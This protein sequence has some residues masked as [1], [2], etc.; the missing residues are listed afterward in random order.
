MCWKGADNIIASK[1]N[2]RVGRDFTISVKWQKITFLLHSRKVQWED[3]YSV[4]CTWFFFFF[5]WVQSW[6]ITTTFRGPLLMLGW[7]FTIF[8]LSVFVQLQEFKDSSLPWGSVLICLMACE[9]FLQRFQGFLVFP[10]TRC[11]NWL[12][13]CWSTMQVYPWMFLKVTAQ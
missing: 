11:I 2:F 12:L 5:S 8:L 4:C 13:L 9:D 7:F 1:D 10:W 3:E 6:L